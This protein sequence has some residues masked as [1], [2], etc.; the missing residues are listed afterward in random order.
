MFSPAARPLLDG[1]LDGVAGHVGVAGLVHRVAK[2]EVAGG[3][4][5]AVLGGHDDG[6]ADLGPDLA[7]PFVDDGLA[8]LDLAPLVVAGHGRSPKAA[9][10]MARAGDLIDGPSLAWPSLA[11]PSLGALRSR[12]RSW[13][14]MGLQGLSLLLA[15][16]CGHGL[17]IDFLFGE[18]CDGGLLLVLGGAALG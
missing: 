16:G 17:G 3:V 10:A 4:A 12:R 11:W 7:A 15:G 13:P 9:R 14:V 1:P 6:L 5:P 18:R 2:G 8:V